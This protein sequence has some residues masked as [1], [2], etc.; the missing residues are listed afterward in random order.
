VRV[1]WVAT[2]S[3][4]PAVDGGRLVMAETLAALAD[5]G[6]GGVVVVPAEQD[7]VVERGAWRLV[8]VAAAPRWLQ[9]AGAVRLRSVA[10]ASHLQPAVRRAV[11]RLVAHERIDVVHAEQIHALPQCAAASARGIPVVLR[12]QN[13]EHEVFA[14]RRRSRL[15]APFVRGERRRLAAF[16]ARAVRAAAVAIAL[17]APDA[18]RL[19]VLAGTPVDHVPAPFRAELPAGPP[20]AGSP[21]VVLFGSAGWFP[22][23]DVVDWFAAAVWPAVRVELPAARLHVVGLPGKPDPAA[24]IVVHPSPAESAAAF[25][26]G[27]ILAVPSRVSSGIR[28]K[29]LEAWARGL[30]VVA[31]PEATSGLGTADGEGA[32]LASDGRAF[33]AAIT[34]LHADPALARRLVASGRTRLAREHDPGAVARRLLQVY[35][36]VCAPVSAPAQPRRRVPAAAAW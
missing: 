3:P 33:A 11:A 30:P 23:R 16:E 17:T 9:L 15:V 19:A 24:G 7:G 6:A 35:E 4:E 5:A 10:V 2:K 14:A 25:A 31:T 26:Q 34:R 22:N 28:M 18:E 36:R 21:A 32:L 29:I 12:A 1:L 27:A 8:S 20:L 13:V